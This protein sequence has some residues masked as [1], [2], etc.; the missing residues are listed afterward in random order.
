VAQLPKITS[1]WYALSKEGKEKS[2]YGFSRKFYPTYIELLENDVTLLNDYFNLED[3]EVDA[4]TADDAVIDDNTGSLQFTGKVTMS[5]ASDVIARVFLNY[6]LG[7]AEAWWVNI[8][9]SRGKM[10]YK[11]FTEYFEEET[12]KDAR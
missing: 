12:A 2:I 8:R 7:G 1:L 10:F 5:L 9:G 3:S 6:S 11:L 4:G